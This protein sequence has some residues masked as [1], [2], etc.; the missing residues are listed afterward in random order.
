MEQNI[1]P[2][3]DLQ[4]QEQ[5][6]GDW[7]L[8]GEGDLKGVTLV[9]HRGTGE[10]VSLSTR[11]QTEEDRWED[12]P[13]LSSYPSFEILDLHKSRYITEFDASVC[14]AP[15]LRR[16][17][18]TNCSQLSTISPSIRS[19]KH[20]TEVGPEFCDVVPCPWDLTPET[21]S[22]AVTHL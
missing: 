20:L 6:E 22:L 19:L 11:S 14:M 9:V 8:V 21:H 10:A 12:V 3:R 18:L 2:Q 1:A 13:D 7:I 5:S 17:L 15:N 16:L 4:I